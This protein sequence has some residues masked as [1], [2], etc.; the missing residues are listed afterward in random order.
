[1]GGEKVNFFNLFP[2]QFCRGER[3]CEW[4]SVV[5]RALFSGEGVEVIV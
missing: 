2:T 1:M 4:V 3:L 5:N